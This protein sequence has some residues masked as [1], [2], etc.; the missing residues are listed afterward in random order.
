MASMRESELS[1]IP[2]CCAIARSPPGSAEMILARPPI[3]LIC[4]IWPRRSSIVKPSRSMRSAASICSWS[5]TFWA[6][7][8]M[9]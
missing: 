8:M 2:P 3:F 9:P 1:S 4:C 5:A 7:S 6:C